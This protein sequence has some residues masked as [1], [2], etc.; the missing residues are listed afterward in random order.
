M[1]KLKMLRAA[2]RWTL[3]RAD[4]HHGI[5]G[6]RRGRQC[7]DREALDA[8]DAAGRPV[9]SGYMTIE[10]HGKVDDRLTGGSSP[11]AANVEV[12]EMKAEGD[13]MTMRR[14]EGGLAIPAGGSATLE[15]AAT[16]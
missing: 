6:G 10:N 13:V 4:G 2:R 8:G 15:P 3:C 16:T 14:L 9:A 5:R 12:H 11:I 7:P 1:T